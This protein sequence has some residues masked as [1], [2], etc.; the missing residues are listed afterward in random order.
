MLIYF[1][2]LVIGS[3]IVPAII[4][5]VFVRK[6]HKPL[7]VKDLYTN[8]SYCEYNRA[9]NAIGKANSRVVEKDF[10]EV[11]NS[12]IEQLVQDKFIIVTKE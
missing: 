1:I 4:S 6:K 12:G 10:K 2:F 5:I 11:V 7:V 8:S 3:F 9:S